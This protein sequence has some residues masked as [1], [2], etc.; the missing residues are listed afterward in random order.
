[1]VYVEAVLRTFYAC[2]RQQ[3]ISARISD[4]CT[5]EYTAREES[6]V[7]PAARGE[8]QAAARDERP[9]AAP[10]STGHG[11]PQRGLS[12]GPV[13]YHDLKPSALV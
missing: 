5:S 10:S 13:R 6:C 1:M 3:P 9:A 8:S 2:T 4:F 11:W 12:P 7:E